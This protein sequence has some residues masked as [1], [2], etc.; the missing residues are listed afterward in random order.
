MMKLPKFFVVFTLIAVSLMML[1]S[2]GNTG[3][4][5]APT[6][7]RCEYLTNPL[8]IDSR[9]PKFNWVVNDPDRGEKQNAYQIIVASSQANIDA[10]TGDKWDSGMVASSQQTGVKYNGGAL[11]SK[12][13]YWWKVKTWDK[14]NNPSPWSPAANFETAFLVT[15]DYVECGTRG[16]ETAHN[17]QAH[18]ASATGKEGGYTRRYSTSASGTWFSYD[19]SVPVNIDAVKFRIRYTSDGTAVRDY[20][21]YLDGTLMEHISITPPA[22]GGF[23]YT[24]TYTGLSSKTGDGKLTIKFEEENPTQNYDPSIANIWVESA[25]AADQWTAGWIGGDSVRRLRKN[26]TISKTVAKARAYVSGQGYFELRINGAKVGDQVLAPGLTEYNTRSLYVTYDI[27]SYLTSGNNA[28]GL[29]LGSGFRYELDNVRKA[30]CQLEIKFTDGTTATVNSDTGWKSSTGGAVTDENEYSHEYYDARNEDDW[31]K[32]G[33]NDA[34]WPAAAAQTGPDIL[35]AQMM[36]PLKVVETITPVDRTNPQS[37]VYVFDMGQNFS[38]WVQ[39]NVAGSAGTVVTLKFAE[40]K[41]GSGM[42]DPR[43]CFHNPQCQYTLKGSGAEVWEP[44]FF[45]TGFRYVEVTGFPGTP[46]VNDIKGRVV[47]SAVETIGS[48]NCSDATINSIQKLYLWAQ[49]S[50]LRGYPVDCPQREK[51]GWTG[52]ANVTS[53]SALYNYDLT[54]FYRKWLADIRDCQEQDTGTGDYSVVVPV[55]NKDPQSQNPGVFYTFVDLPWLS[56]TVLIPWDVYMA[57][58]DKSIL[59]EHYYHMKW[60][61]DWIKSQDSDNNYLVEANNFGDWVGITGTTTSLLSTGYWYRCADLMSKIATALGKTSDAATYSTLAANIK[62]AFNSQ[63]LIS[64]DHYDNATQCANSIPLYF[65]MVPDANKSNVVNS[66]VN[67]IVNRTNHLS[68]GVLGTKAIMEALWKNGRPDKAFDLAVQTTF[69]SWGNMVAQGCTTLREHWQQYGT[70]PHPAPD[71]TWESQNHCMF[72]GGPGTW[73]YKGLA[74]ISPTLAGYEEILIKP[75]V[76]GSLTSAAGSIKTVR[77]TVSTGWTKSGNTLTLNLTLP[78][79]SKGVVYITTLG[80]GASACTIKEGTT[81][82][83]QNGSVQGSVTGVTYKTTD[84]DCVVWDV[85][86]GI[87][88]FTMTKNGTT[89]TPTPTPTVTPTPTP[90]GSTLLADDFSGDLSKWVNTANASI[91]GGQ[92]TLTNNEIMRSVAGGAG[93]TDYTYQADAKI[94]AIGAGLVFRSQDDNNYYMWQLNANGK[95]RPHKKVAGAWTVIKEVVAGITV[96]TTYTVKVETVGP[97]IKTY[98]NGS[99]IDTTID[100]AF[101]SGKM[102]FREAVSETAVFDNVLVTTTGFTQAPRNGASVSST[103][104]SGWAASNAIDSNNTTCW[105]SAVQSQTG[106]QWIYIDLGQ[107]YS[108]K[109]ARLY[110]RT[111]SGTVYCFPI[112]FKF[113]YGTDGTN[114]TDVP[115]QSYTNYPKPSNSEQVFTFGSAVTARYIRLYGTKF[116]GDDFNNYYLQIAELNGDY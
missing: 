31:D 54:K 50:A 29:W 20:N 58:G 2:I 8:G 99:L 27:T 85:G 23:I 61:M 22:A 82:I 6:D 104:S 111:S 62:S 90:G 97:A 59:E 88:S 108:I 80:A 19:L 14:D 98:L 77:G 36:E 100:T 83:W 11:S 66:L 16:S 65:G 113:Q 89:P 55:P 78:V 96:G 72:G 12:T 87:Y 63:W 35:A 84:G 115:G 26:F 94:T 103:V 49:R 102:G 92:L 38:G 39:L 28:V 53:E 47:H 64:G 110:P 75:D 25:T 57:T 34:S 74:G 41:Y 43:S 95:L 13:Q 37:G 3:A 109:R 42:I 48:F 51:R 101:T 114:W 45:Y 81:V 68:T 33:F 40:L 93:W 21:L 67:D 32:A 73:F 10:G 60:F 69:P 71:E 44:R 79:N 15:Y 91:S 46:T 76:V 86:S 7:L 70:T 1:T 30:I 18:A 116:G 107:N 112:D 105:S 17:V 106:A 56:A 24:K 52:D 9:I 5:N 4:P